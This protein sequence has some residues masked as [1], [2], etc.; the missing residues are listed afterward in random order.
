MCAISMSY[1]N[2]HWY[3]FDFKYLVVKETTLYCPQYVR[4]IYIHHD[5]HLNTT[6]ILSASI[7]LKETLRKHLNFTLNI[8]N[9]QHQSEY[10]L[11]AIKSGSVYCY[12]TTGT[13]MNSSVTGPDRSTVL[14]SGYCTCWA[15]DCRSSDDRWN[16]A[17][18]LLP[19]RG[20][21]NYRT[22]N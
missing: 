13:T 7:F 3:Y 14:R 22:G 20:W 9:K 17:A 21:L 19:W 15:A 6:Y 2:W 18:D 5:F 12:G 4:Y 16:T 11:S 8:S 1:L 10:D